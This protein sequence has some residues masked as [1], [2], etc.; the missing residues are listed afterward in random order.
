MSNMENCSICSLVR[1]D[2][3]SAFVDIITFSPNGK[4]LASGSADKNINI[5]SV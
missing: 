2:G 1:L 4:Y 3:H 5:W